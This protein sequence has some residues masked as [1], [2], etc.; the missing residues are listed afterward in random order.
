M[1]KIA[2]PVVNGQLNCHFGHT[3]QFYVYEIGNNSII[4][5]LILTPPPH[6]PGL[7]PQWLSEIGVTDIIAGGM[8]RKAIALFNL[9]KI[10]VFIGVPVKPPK[11]LVIDYLDRTLETSDNTCDH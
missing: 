8:G 6:E 2:I 3:Q 10:N 5:E 4:K 9:K 11:E 1:N 7:F